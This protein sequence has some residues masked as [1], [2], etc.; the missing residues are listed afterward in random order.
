LAVVKLLLTV[1]PKVV[2]AFQPNR[3]VWLLPGFAFSRRLAAIQE[4]EDAMAWDTEQASQK[5]PCPDSRLAIR[6][7]R[8]W[9]SLPK[10]SDFLRLA[11]ANIRRATPGFVL[12]SAPRE[13]GAPSALRIGFTASRKVGNAVARSRTKRR[14]RALAD[15]VMADAADPA[16]DYV[17]IGRTE[18]LRR[19]FSA[20]ERD[21]RHALKKLA[22]RK[23]SEGRS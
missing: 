10:R 16:C 6:R 17:L 20:M 9:K 2:S 15:K 8:P 4:R 13:T 19:D 5:L 12:Q 21:L 3:L 22:E 14:L 7:G 1:A 23:L 18:T 11:A